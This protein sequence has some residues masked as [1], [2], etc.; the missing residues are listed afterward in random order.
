MLRTVEVLIG[1]AVHT[2]IHTQ[3][4]EQ[5]TQQCLS[6]GKLCGRVNNE[7]H[8]RW[9]HRAWL[10]TC[11]TLLFGLFKLGYSV[12]PLFKAREATRARQATRAH[13]LRVIKATRKDRRGL[14]ERGRE[15]RG[16]EE[17]G[18]GSAR[19]A[20][21]LSCKRGRPP[22]FGL[23]RL[24]TAG[25][26]DSV[27]WAGQCECDVGSTHA[28]GACTESVLCVLRIGIDVRVCRI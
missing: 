9:G 18:D 4:R 16:R 14:E 7:K 25:N 23:L 2:W 20:I 5:T 27:T 3:Q 21:C 17:R 10:R 13:H 22:L 6:G 12:R 1:V 15:E 28:V 24:S 19:F 8:Y 11:D 26:G